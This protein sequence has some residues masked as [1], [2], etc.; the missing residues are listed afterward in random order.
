MKKSDLIILI[1][2]HL[3]RLS[4]TKPSYKF[5]VQA[6]NVVIKKIKSL[7][8]DDI[9]SPIIDDMDLTVYMKS[10]LKE[11]IKQPISTIPIELQLQ[12]IAGIGKVLA[13]SLKKQGVKAISDLKKSQYFSQLPE[14]A[15]ID[16]K[17]HPIK[18]IPRYLIE[19]LEYQLKRILKL[20]MVFV[21][22]YR[23]HKPFSSD[24]D[25]LIRQSTLDKYGG[26]L[27]F[28]EYINSHQ[29]NIKLYH[30]YA[31]G[32]SKLSTI[33]RLKKYKKNVKVDMFITTTEEYPFALL[34]TTGSKEF[35]IRM[36][37]L[38]K[39]KGML[40]NQNGLYKTKQHKS[41]RNTKPDLK[42]KITGLKTE[43]SIFEYLNMPFL[44][45]EE[46]G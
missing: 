10:K 35:N 23:R 6:Y 30:P 33:C 40:L 16:I 26:S 21:G 9:T 41:A 32:P 19:H 12:D 45:P 7:E 22:S 18:P 42:Q 17:Y 14:A 34:Y 38:A 39:L 4:N 27:K 25:I 8:S 5:Q 2:Q 3:D 24:V 13:R 37:R 36:R 44:K 43:K 15:Q 31:I 20:P 29:S 46:R 11:L 1:K 28:I